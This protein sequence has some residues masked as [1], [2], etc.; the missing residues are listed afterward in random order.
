[1]W[2]D[3]IVQ[4]GNSQASKIAGRRKRTCFTK[5]HLEL[6]RMAFSVDPYPGISVRESLSQATGLPE[7]RI[8]VWFQNKRARTLKNRVART[9][10]QL[11][12]TSPMPSPFL[13]PYLASV[14]ANGQ[15]RGIQEG[16]FSLPQAQMPQTSPHHFTFPPRDYSTPSV[17]PRQ[18]RLM[19]TSSCSPSFP[20]DLQAMA[21]SWSSGE[22]TQS[23][24]ESTWSPAAQSFGNSYNDEGHV[25]PYPPPPYPHG[26][27]RVECASGLESLPISPGSC[28]SAF[29]EM[30]LE[31]STY[32][33]CDTPWE[34]LAEVQSVAPLPDLGP[35]C[36]ED[37]LDEMQPAWWN[38][39]GQIDLQ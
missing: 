14:G 22:S 5:E 31:N 7:S 27:A 21:D 36:L 24:P 34:M 30:G 12:S 38:L 18:N 15:Q 28:D 16:A 13:P 17:K 6:L 9:S 1:M 3:C 2:S 4:D 37:V 26:S 19:G 29:W 20:V 33:E 32:T 23:S 35:E 10:P 39:N 8:Q 25:S 11:D